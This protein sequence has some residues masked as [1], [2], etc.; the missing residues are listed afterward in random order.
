MTQGLYTRKKASNAKSERDLINAPF[1]Y[2]SGP[3]FLSAYLKLMDRSGNDDED[4]ELDTD[5]YR[6]WQRR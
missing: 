1:K 2:I 6:D 3:N 5:G 4:G